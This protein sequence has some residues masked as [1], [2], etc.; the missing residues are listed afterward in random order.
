LS[1]NGRELLLTHQLYLVGA[2]SIM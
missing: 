1:E 2:S